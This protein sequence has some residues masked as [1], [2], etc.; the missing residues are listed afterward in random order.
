M[1]DHADTS[2]IAKNPKRANTK[3]YALWS[4]YFMELLRKDGLLHVLNEELPD[5]ETATVT[6]V[7]KFRLED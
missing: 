4:I 3:G 1:S 5:H 7:R 6:A 2:L